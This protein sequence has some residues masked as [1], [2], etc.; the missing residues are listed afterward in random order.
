MDVYDAI[1][2]RRSIR[3]FDG[4]RDVPSELVEKL[5][6]AACQAPSAGNV[7]PWLFM[8]I[9]DS[10]L[11]SRLVVAARGQEF[12][13]QAP[14]VVAVCAN[15]QVASGSYG[16]RGTKLYAI[17]DTAA[18]TE[19]LLLAAYAEGLGSCWVGAFDEE[20]AAQA[21]DLPSHVRPVALVP[22]GFAK[23]DRRKPSKK[24]I[25]EVTRFL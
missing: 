6:E 24:P 19:N 15:L 18:A 9:R 20:M 11:K 3:S 14:V 13:R 1:Y 7:Q 12:I 2:G 16:L 22:I 4:D 10:A 21:L 8:A 23:K 25:S 5:L 17:Q